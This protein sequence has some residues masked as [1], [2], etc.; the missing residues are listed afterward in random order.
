[1]DSLRQ[2]LCAFRD[3]ELLCDVKIHSK[4]GTHLAHKVMLAAAS[5]YFKTLLLSDFVE[6]H[7]GIVKLEDIGSDLI[8]D[9]LQYIYSG[10][11]D[12][13][14]AN[15][16]ELFCIADRL[17]VVGLKRACEEFLLKKIDTSNCLSIMR[18]AHSVNEGSLEKTAFRFIVENFQDFISTDDF[19]ELTIA[20]F[21]A[22]VQQGN[23][24]I[25]KE[26]D[27]YEAVISWANKNPEKRDDA[28]PDI[29]KHVRFPLM[30][31]E[32]LETN[33]IN[34][35]RIDND[36]WNDTIFDIYQRTYRYF[37]REK[38]D[39]FFVV[40]RDLP[41]YSLQLRPPSQLICVIG[42][43][44]NGRCLQVTECYNP[45]SDEWSL[46][47]KLKDPSGS[48][49]YYGSASIDKKIYYAGV[50]TRSWK[51]YFCL[52]A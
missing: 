29:L 36:K 24:Y 19:Y 43:W 49:C 13:D 30:S 48:R 27:L 44:S 34:S 2:T 1:M 9:L 33:I 10:S 14:E 3:Q 47:T 37:K 52:L 20:E 45:K 28:L 22:I 39:A 23:L 18:V 26:E 32:F 38:K 42:G 11:L 31:L 15:G 17:E 46:S 4:D 6:A 7:S 12:I 51:L 50:V 35:D 41:C 21:T 5:S 8:A 25:E 40:P 16:F